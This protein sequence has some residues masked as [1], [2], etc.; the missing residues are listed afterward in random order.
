[1]SETQ[2]STAA[3]I[4]DLGDQVTYTVESFDSLPQPP[5][6]AIDITQT[7]EDGKYVLRYAVR[8]GDSPTTYQI[9]GSTS[10]EPLGTHPMFGPDG[11][12]P[13]TDDEWKNWKIWEADPHDLTLDGWT[14]DGD[15]ASDGMKKFFKYRN[16]GIEDYLLGTVNMRVST[17]ETSSPPLSALAK[18]SKPPNAP[19]LADNRNWL[20]V[21]ID[22][23]RI[24]YGGE[25]WKITREYR[26]SAAGGWD[27]EIYSKA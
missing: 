26:A 7:L 5:S 21:G 23:E 9:T 11:A 1:M 3:K 15:G 8:E 12:Y 14:P 22:A 24:A 27:P 2:T 6:N 25:R 19:T 10:Q 18:I 4:G 13:V 17:E 20:C 16:R